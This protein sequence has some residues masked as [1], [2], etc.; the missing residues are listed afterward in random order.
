MSKRKLERF[1][2]LDTFKNVFQPVQSEFICDSFR[3]K[4]NWSKDFFKNQNPIIL[5]LGCGKGE[6]T[7]GL[8]EKFPEI[9]FI[10]V[11]IKGD[12]I[13]RGSKT[14]LD[15]SLRNVAFLRTQIENI[16]FFF[17]KDEVSEI[18]I[19]FPD[20]QPNK[21]KIKKRLTS[22][23]FLECYKKILKPDG[24]I[25][26]KTDNINLFDYTLEVINDGGHKL[27]FSTNDLYNSSVSGEALSIRTYYEQ[28][29]LNQNLPIRYLKFNHWWTR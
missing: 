25:H 24:I 5:E 11:D 2:E 6:Y 1:A 29:F 26:L 23:Q 15:K 10:G 28:M 21:P 9:N 7:V 16:T 4:G 3:L 22:P 14:A 17:G 19:T 18:W 13:W 20:P 8:A 12:R 27:L